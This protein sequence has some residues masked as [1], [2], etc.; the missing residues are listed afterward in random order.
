[1]PDRPNPDDPTPAPVPPALAPPPG[2]MVVVGESLIKSVVEASRTSPR[3]RTI[4]PLHKRLDDP[5]Q[6]MLN[7][8][9]PGSYVRPHRHAP[10]V[11]EGLVVLQGAL[12]FIAFADDGEI[13][14]AVDLGAGGD[15]GVDVESDVYHTLVALAPDSVIYEVKTGPYRPANDKSFAPWAPAE[16]TPDAA[17][18]LQDLIARTTPHG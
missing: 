13:R 2:A 14:R 17:R 15:L 11:G 3:R 1:M 16:D 8:I 9:Q 7:A 4:L 6:R 18:Y 12:R 5:L 10:P